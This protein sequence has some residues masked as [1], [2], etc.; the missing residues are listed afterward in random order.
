MEVPLVEAGWTVELA[1]IGAGPA[2]MAA[3]VAASE[4]GVECLVVDECTEPGGRIYSGLASRTGSEGLFGD[5][6]VRG[7]E[8]ME[9]FRASGARQAMSARLWEID[10]EGFLL[11]SSEGRSSRIAAR[12]VILATGAQER[13]MPLPGWT[14]PGVMTAGGAQI[15]YKREGLVPEGPVVLAGTGPLLF[16][17]AWQYLRAGIKVAGVLVTSGARDVSKAAPYLPAA[18]VSGPLAAKGGKLVT[19]LVAAGVRLA[20][21]VTKIEAQG[22]EQLERVSYWKGTRSHSMPASVLLLH[23]GIV[24]DT[25]VLRRLRDPLLWDPRGRYWHAKT[26]DFGATGIDFLAVAGDGNRIVGAEAAR[27]QGSLAGYDAAMRLGKMGRPERDRR[28]TGAIQ[29]LAAMKRE[30]R[31]LD[32]LFA[33]SSEFLAPACDDTIVCRCEDVTAGAI[34]RAVASSITDSNRLKTLLRCGMGP[35]QGRF[36]ELTVAEIVGTMSGAR[37]ENN[38]PLRIRPPLKP[39]DVE[40][41]I[42]MAGDDEPAEARI[43]I[44]RVAVRSFV[45]GH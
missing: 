12:R 24:P 35:C 13:P 6:Y 31:F 44:R 34:R 32:T 28:T 25:R 45:D 37:P 18:I 7:R 9:A 14:L 5:D 15:L 21:G 29:R 4:S 1:I 17:L 8:L 39:V 27:L 43:P 40:E 11:I 3:A 26:D 19:A 36:C 2:G 30:R 23:Q 10:S 20:F 33:P 22:K 42:A 38:P 16:L 41:F